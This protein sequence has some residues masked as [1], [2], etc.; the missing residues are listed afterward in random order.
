MTNDHHSLSDSCTMG[1]RFCCRGGTLCAPP[2][3]D[4]CYPSCHWN[5]QG[6]SMRRLGPPDVEMK[7][8][9]WIFGFAAGF[10]LMAVAHPG[11]LATDGKVPPANQIV[12]AGSLLHVRLESTVTSKTSKTGDPFTGMVTDPV[13]VNGNE[14]VPSGSTVEGHVAFV[15]DSG[16]IKGVAQMRLVLDAVITP[17]DVKL[18]LPAGLDDLNAGPCAKT[19]RDEEGTIKGCGKS[20][21]DAAKGA[22]LGAAMGAG[23]GSSVGLGSEIDCRYYGNCGGPGLGTS[24]GAGAGIGAGTALIYHLLKHEKHIILVR[25]TTL[26]FVINRSVDTGTSKPLEAHVAN[27]K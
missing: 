9:K 25:G 7:M 26:T 15:K 12:P 20:K 11:A 21:K 5:T 27:A 4:I 2:L 13:V 17:D 19:T 14:V 8:R 1:T 22:G 3:I 24:I 18:V 6:K 10:L 16:R 23:V